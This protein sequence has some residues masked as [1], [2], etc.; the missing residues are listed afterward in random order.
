[1]DIFKIVG[2]GIAATVFAVLI[3]D[4][5]P[6][7]AIQISLVASVIIFIAAAPYLKTAITMFEDISSRIGMESKY[8]MI[9]L[10]IIGIAYAA[11]FGAELCRDAGENAVATR[12]EFAGKAI[13]ITLSMPIMYQLL[14]V[15]ESILRFG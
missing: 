14:E 8:I 10:K 7:I 11:Q 6:E 12:I 5:R 9:V 1:M 4:K 13:I 15:V 2:L 3:K